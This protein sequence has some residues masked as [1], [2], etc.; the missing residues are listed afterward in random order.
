VTTVGYDEYFIINARE[1]DI[2]SEALNVDSNMTKA[3]VAKEFLR[4]AEKKT[5]NR[6]LL[7]RIID[8]VTTNAKV[9]VL[10]FG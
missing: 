8:R 4:F 6:V 1:M 7:G 5:T 10:K 9:K 2:R 3:K